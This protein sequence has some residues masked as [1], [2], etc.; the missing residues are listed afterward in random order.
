MVSLACI[1]ASDQ[2]AVPFEIPKIQEI[3]FHKIIMPIE[4]S[5]VTCAPPTSPNM[6]TSGSVDPEGFKTAAH[7]SK[8][9]VMVAHPYTASI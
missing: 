3:S 9:D 4:V 1:T 8:G 5:S 6:V 7:Y 2:C